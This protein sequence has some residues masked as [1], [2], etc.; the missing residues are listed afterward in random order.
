MVNHKSNLG[1]LIL[2]HLNLLCLFVKFIV[3]NISPSPPGP[4]DGGGGV[5]RQCGRPWPL[6]GRPRAPRRRQWPS[7]CGRPGPLAVRA[8]QDPHY[9]CMYIYIY[10]YTNIDTNIYIYIYVIFCICVYIYIYT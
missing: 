6:G 5:P 1:F 8:P 2:S 10:I 7:R 4:Y 3:G 9:I